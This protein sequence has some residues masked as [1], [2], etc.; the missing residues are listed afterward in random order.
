M[1]DLTSMLSSFLNRF[2]LTGIAHTA[3]AT[4]RATAQTAAVASVCA[5]TVGANDASFDV[6]MNVLVTT[7]TTHTFTGQ[8]TYTDEG[9]SAR[10]ITMPF[11][12]VGST[13]AMVTS[14]T[15]ANGTVPYIGS[16]VRIRAQAATAI[17][18]LTQ[19]AGTYTT[20]VFNVEGSIVSA[21][22]AY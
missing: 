10:T 5:Y 8:C 2:Y 3:V 22:S 17:T 9:G 20:V 13:T 12:L 21:G 16:P 11:R 19:A 18:L 14:I 7:A 6:C 1:A 15:N 4:G